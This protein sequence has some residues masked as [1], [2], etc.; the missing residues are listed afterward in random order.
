MKYGQSEEIVLIPCQYPI[1]IMLL[2]GDDAPPVIKKWW[3]T[4]GPGISPTQYLVLWRSFTQDLIE[5]HGHGAFLT[6]VQIRA[7]GDASVQ[8]RLAGESPTESRRRDAFNWN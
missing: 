8:F 5:R 1:A 3:Q 2:D 7:N 6:A 4:D